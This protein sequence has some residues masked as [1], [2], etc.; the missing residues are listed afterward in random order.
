[1]RSILSKQKNVVEQKCT[2]ARSADCIFAEL[3]PPKGGEA[4]TVC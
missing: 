1:M 4:Y 3:E 2:K